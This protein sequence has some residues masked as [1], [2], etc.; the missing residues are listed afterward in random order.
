MTDP[1]K[2]NPH[3][4]NGDD[5]KALSQAVH[6]RGMLLMVDVAINAIASQPTDISDAS[7]AQAEGGSLLFKHQ[8]N[9]HPKCTINWGNH[10]TEQRW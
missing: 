3:F 6:D 4:G 7:L 10:D 8:A 2:L 9:Y 1:T 5:L